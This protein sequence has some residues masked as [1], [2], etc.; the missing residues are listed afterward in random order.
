[1]KKRVHLS[2]P[3]LL[4][5]RNRVPDTVGRVERFNQRYGRT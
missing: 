4:H 3:P 2:Q 1:M 5:G